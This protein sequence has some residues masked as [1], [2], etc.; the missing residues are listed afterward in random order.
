ML[1]TVESFSR[2]FEHSTAYSHA[3]TKKYPLVRVFFCGAAG[4]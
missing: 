1:L 2:A 3:I 4:S